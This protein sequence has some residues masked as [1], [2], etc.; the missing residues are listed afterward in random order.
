[1]NKVNYILFFFLCSICYGQEYT[2]EKKDSQSLQADVFIGADTF[3]NVYFINDRTLFK[4]GRSSNAQYTALSLGNIS[5]VDIINPLK[6]TVFYQKTNVVV[7]LD[8]TLSEIRRIDFNAIESFRNV[9]HATTAT[10]RRLWIFNT[11]LQQLELFDYNI[12]QVVT[13]FQPIQKLA[14]L[15]LSNFNLCHVLA[16]SELL[17][18]NIY[19]A[20]LERYPSKPFVQL[21]EYNN[22]L[23]GRTTEEFYYKAATSKDFSI[24][25]SPEIEVKGFYLID[26]ILYIYNGQELSTYQL[27]PI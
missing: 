9:S 18:Y 8:N 3:D 2:L 1:M 16:N 17:T 21:R 5:S 12:L 4:K 24:L 10:D 11:D 19:G 22:H 25:I 14:D 27:K 20:L 7:I 26:E 23:L 15:Q 6:I 13:S